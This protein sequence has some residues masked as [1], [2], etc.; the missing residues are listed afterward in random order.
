MRPMLLV[1]LA[2]GTAS[3]AHA[4]QEEAP[5]AVE[6]SA[7]CKQ[8][9]TIIELNKQLWQVFA[10]DDGKSLAIVANSGNPAAPY[11]FVVAAMTDN[12]AI[13]GDGVGDVSS[14]HAAGRELLTWDSVKIQNLHDEAANIGPQVLAD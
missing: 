12:Y 8:G 9:P 13:R 7:V 5:Q 6:F 2:L 11:V 10:C 4:A 3:M 1:V 14:A